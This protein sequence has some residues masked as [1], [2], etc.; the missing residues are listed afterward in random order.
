LF[1]VFFL[2]FFYT[3]HFLPIKLLTLSSCRRIFRA[4]GDSAFPLYWCVCVCGKNFAPNTQLTEIELKS[5]KLKAKKWQRRRKK[6]QGM[7]SGATQLIKSKLLF[8]SA[9]VSAFDVLQEFKKVVQKLLSTHFKFSQ[10]CKRTTHSLPST[11]NNIWQSVIWSVEFDQAQR[12]QKVWKVN[13]NRG[14]IITSGG[15]CP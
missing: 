4:S 5:W 6:G 13:N 14:P 8:A 12:W 3:W 7:P 1:V 11:K 10:M 2:S 15:K 9:K